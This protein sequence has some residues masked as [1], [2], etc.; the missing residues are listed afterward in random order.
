M[1]FNERLK[2]LRIKANLSQKELSEK[3]GVTAR[4]I[5][6]YELGSSKPKSYETI[7]SLA[8]ALNTT[9][10]YL[11]G[12][13]GVIVAEAYDKGGAKAA[14]DINE[15]VGEVKGVFAGGQLDD[16]ALDNVMQA[17]QEAYW[18]AKAENKKYGRK[19]KKDTTDGKK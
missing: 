13:A 8:N 5:Q 10:E 1:L 18:M 16:S 19:K 14:R 12:K 3:T 17:L 4:T 15:L 9:P 7:V 11:A 6:N 2:E